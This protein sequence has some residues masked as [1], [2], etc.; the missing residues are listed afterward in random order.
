MNNLNFDQKHYLA[1]LGSGQEGEVL[2]SMTLLGHALIA[3]S[4]IASKKAASHYEDEL[5]KT[6]NYRN[7]QPF[8]EYVPKTP[9]EA[10]L[11]DDFLHCS[12]EATAKWEIIRALLQQRS[13]QA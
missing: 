4:W 10:K 11:Y 8:T 12:K 13:D 7:I 5:N 9:S 6:E 1:N 3:K 2:A